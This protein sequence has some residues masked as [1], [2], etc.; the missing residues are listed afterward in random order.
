[1]RVS[2]K[3]DH[4]SVNRPPIISSCKRRI[5]Q[6]TFWQTARAPCGSNL[7]LFFFSNLRGGL[8]PIL[9]ARSLWYSIVT[10]RYDVV[11]DS[12]KSSSSHRHSVVLY[13]TIRYIQ[14]LL[15]ISILLLLHPLF[16]HIVQDPSVDV[17]TNSQSLVWDCVDTWETKVHSSCMCVS[18]FMTFTLG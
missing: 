3:I 5:L 10:Q 15:S 1:M 17:L 7:K 9:P 11:V 2:V 13:P 14:Q 12:N 6:L 16:Y 18:N 8:G 4:G